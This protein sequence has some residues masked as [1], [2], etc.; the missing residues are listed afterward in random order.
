MV[1]TR[2]TLT[3]HFSFRPFN[4]SGNGLL[5]IVR[6]FWV[7]EADACE[8][9]KF[10]RFSG[11]IVLSCQT[12]WLTAQQ[13]SQHQKKNC[14]FSFVSCSRCLYSVGAESGFNLFG[15]CALYSC[16]SFRL[17]VCGSKYA[18]YGDIWR[19]WMCERELFCSLYFNHHQ[20][21]EKKIVFHHRNRRR[22]QRYI[23]QD[24]CVVFGWLVSNWRVHSIQQHIV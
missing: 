10:V 5:S 9:G 3:F 12:L 11:E 19:W 1:A 7:V 14:L 6:L 2:Y 15:F 4:F 20:Q 8:L 17:S 22:C 16:V 21:R 24:L 23:E 18:V 13:L